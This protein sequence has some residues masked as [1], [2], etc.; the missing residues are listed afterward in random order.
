MKPTVIG[1][2]KA[3]CWLVAVS[4]SSKQHHKVNEWVDFDLNN[5]AYSCSYDWILSI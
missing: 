2:P 5:N 1:N 3:V 4:V